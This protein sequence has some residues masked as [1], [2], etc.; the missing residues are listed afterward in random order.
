[1]DV[2]MDSVSVA[3]TFKKTLAEKG[4][5]VRLFSAHPKD[6]IAIP[7]GCSRVELTRTSQAVCKAPC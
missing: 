6:E 5:R 7:E 2:V 3:T 1:M 4:I